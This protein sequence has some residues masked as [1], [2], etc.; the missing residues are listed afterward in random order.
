MKI[1]HLT[2][3]KKWFD[4]VQSGEKKEEYREIKPYWNVRLDKQ[5]DAVRFKNG[6]SKD[7]PYFLIELKSI[8]KGIGKAEY[9]ANKEEVYILTLGKILCNEVEEH[10]KIEFK[11]LEK[12]DIPQMYKW[13]NKDFI[14]KW[15]GKG[16]YYDKYENVENK[17]APRTE[18]NSLTKA[19]IV[20]LDKNKIGYIQT[21]RLIDYPEYNKYVQ[22]DPYVAGLDVFIGE[23]EYLN[24]GIGTKI[25]SEF[26]KTIIFNNHGIKGCIVGPEPNNQR[27]IKAYSKAGFTY[28]KTIH[29]IEENQS[30]YLM[31]IK[32]D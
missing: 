1:L 32:Q 20:Y 24:K 31:I 5:Y 28:L 4:K 3:K 30:E 22:A 18:S 10:M 29:V 11:L 7:S 15:F 6:Y 8:K 13:L 9:G 27:A 17:Y 25:I 23:E 19:F 16:E 26:I 2:L 12:S 14:A 21:Y